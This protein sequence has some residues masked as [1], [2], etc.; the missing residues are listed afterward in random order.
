[1]SE[2]DPS[3][4]HAGDSS[5]PGLQN[6]GVDRSGD[7]SVSLKP[8]GDASGEVTTGVSLMPANVHA[9]EAALVGRIISGRYRIEAPI[10]AGGMGAVFRGEHLHM[11]KRVAIK[12]LHAETEGLAGLAAQFE[13]EAMAGAHV[14]HPNVAIA[15][16]FGELDDGSYFLVLEYL[17]GI[18]LA[19]VLERGPMEVPRAVHIAKQIAAGLQA[20]HAMG[21]VHRDVK[22]RNVMLVQ[23]PEDQAKLIDFGF[24]KVET[25]R[26]SVARA[27]EP[28]LDGAL[29]DADTVFGTI[30]YLA[31][32]AAR[33][34]DAVDDRSD[35]YALGAMMYEMFTG[36]R[37]FE[38]AKNAELFHLHRTAP[39]PPF[40]ERAP[41]LAGIVPAAIE[42]VVV[43]LLAKE[44]SQR[45]QQGAD[46]IAA[47]ERAVL[48]STRPPPPVRADESAVDIV[49]PPELAPRS[50]WRAPLILLVLLAAAG[51]GLYFAN[52]R[53]LLDGVLG[54]GADAS[55]GAS[56]DAPLKQE[57]D[58]MGAAAW[59]ARLLAAPA[60]KDWKGGAKALNA[61]ADLDPTALRAPEVAKAAT[62]VAADAA[63]MPGTDPAVDQLFQ[64]L[65][66]RF[67]AE[68]LD[69]LYTLVE[70]RPATDA[71]SKRAMSDLRQ[72][73][74][75][76]RASP[77]L[78]VTV[79]LR[80]VPCEAKADLF[81]RAAA[82]GDKRTLTVLTA[83][84]NQP[85]KGQKDLCC[86]KGNKPLEQTIATLAARTKK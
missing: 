31:P 23:G 86:F 24:A 74:V 7:V 81:D 80:D 43:R 4:R 34:M 10:A 22:P 20:V 42:A 50:P 78:K 62:S 37:P 71:A 61:L 25:E 45:F 3:D 41:E 19:E 67:G 29:H 66:Q 9:R 76:E 11:R 12:I 6:P 55:A 77:A 16:D 47:L 40:R 27:D 33:G 46:V 73:G 32:E 53:G 51:G 35:L 21:I 17:R 48:A 54:P 82:N 70:T 60:A 30:G 28:P 68:G 59:T 5:D 2:R 38:A 64:L 83:L 85:C 15:T 1:V 8:A 58:G 57:V 69:V 63:K 44:P 79:Q 65:A 39:V 75:L 13:R 84:R 18:T 52:E 26:M 56:S 14:S 72:P 49:I 36:K